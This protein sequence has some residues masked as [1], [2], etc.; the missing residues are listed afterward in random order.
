MHP[1]L[2][3]RSEINFEKIVCEERLICR[4]S[5]SETWPEMVGWLDGGGRQ[6]MGPGSDFS[7][8]GNGWWG[9]SFADSQLLLL[10][11]EEEGE[12]QLIIAKHPLKCQL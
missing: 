5:V 8:L 7:P 11:E 1:F 3:K 9:N 6:D 10:Q 2:A 4:E 12:I